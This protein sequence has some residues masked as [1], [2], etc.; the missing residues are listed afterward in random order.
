MTTSDDGAN[1]HLSELIGECRRV[2]HLTAYPAAGGKVC[3]VLDGRLGLELPEAYA[4]AL[5]PFIA[6]CVDAAL[7]RRT[8][9]SPGQDV[10]GNTPVAG[11][12]P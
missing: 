4:C 12:E 11:D 7:G 5:I 9:A 1:S 8:H 10:M 6:D 3:L 2:P